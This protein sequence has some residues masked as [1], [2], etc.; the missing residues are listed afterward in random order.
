MR[1]AGVPDPVGEGDQ[2]IEAGDCIFSI[3]DSAGHYWKTIWDHP[4][5]HQLKQ[6][7]GFCMCFCP[8]TRFTSRRSSLFQRLHA[9]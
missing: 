3:A 4:R 9:S 8:A 6:K 5:N 7:R 1:G 2:T